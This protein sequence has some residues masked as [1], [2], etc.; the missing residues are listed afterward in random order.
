MTKLDLSKGTRIIDSR[1][2]QIRAALTPAGAKHAITSQPYLVK[3]WLDVDATSVIYGQSNTGKSFFALDLALHIAAGRPW[4][5][6]KTTQSNVVYVATEGGKGLSK[7]I[8]AFERE[9]S[10]L[11]EKAKSHFCHLPLQLDL[12]GPDDVDALLTAIRGRAV[13]LVIVDT[14]AMSFG[15]G[16]ENDGKDVTQYLTNVARIRQ[17]LNCHVML[18]HHSGKDMSKGARGHSSLRA[19]VDTEI[20]LTVSGE[21]RVAKATKQR[22]LEGGRLAAFT[23]KAVSLGLDQDGDPITS[24]VVVQQDTSLAKKRKRKP[25]SGMMEVAHQ[26]LTDALIDYGIANSTNPAYP[27]GRKTVSISDWKVHYMKKRAGE[28]KQESLSKDFNRQVNELIKNDY[29]RKQDERVWFISKD[30][31]DKQDM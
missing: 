9:R 2:E 16:S 15:A 20:E 14:L 3:H 17:E 23:L 1:V 24:C 21:L 30:D 4:N 27:T 6:S 18:V 7:R 29:V 28:A 8:L 26:A 5:G 25:L 22:D 11:F 12:H 10:E 13:E 19:A 31:E